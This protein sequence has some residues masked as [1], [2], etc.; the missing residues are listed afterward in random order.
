MHIFFE[1]FLL[2]LLYLV[3]LVYLVSVLL[4]CREPESGAGEC[5]GGAGRI[6]A[7]AALP[8]DRAGRHRGPP[9][10]TRHTQHW[11]TQNYQSVLNVPYIVS[12]S[13][14]PASIEAIIGTF[15]TSAILF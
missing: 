15:S 12:N 2:L 3:F 6:Q 9:R 11:S 7:A 8:D 1:L 10:R 4:W 14:R 5:A 13:S